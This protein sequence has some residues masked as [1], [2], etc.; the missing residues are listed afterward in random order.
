M[1]A[2]VK[3]STK[4]MEPI[5]STSIYSMHLYKCHK[6]AQALLSFKKKGGRQKLIRLALELFGFIKGL[7][8]LMYEMSVIESNSLGFKISSGQAT[9][10]ALSVQCLSYVQLAKPSIM[11]CILPDT[12]SLLYLH[13]V[14]EFNSEQF[15][16][17]SGCHS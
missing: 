13:W 4:H 16:T 8:S 12:K 10:K 17:Y 15:A 14:F 11:R 7:P 2:Q 9:S 6:T 1:L 3:H 5:L